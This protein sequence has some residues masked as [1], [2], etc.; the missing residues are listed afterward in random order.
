MDIFEKAARR[1]LRFETQ[2]G[3]LSVEDLWDLPLTSKTRANLDSLACA[4]YKRIEQS[5]RMSFVAEAKPADSDA[6]LALDILKR[7]IAV[8]QNEAAEAAARREMGK[9]KEKIMEIIER[10][11]DQKLESASVEELRAMVRGLGAN[12]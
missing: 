4:V 11:E 9:Q 12:A 10:K 2:Q 6:I 8:K 3:M 7:V 5:E 1:K